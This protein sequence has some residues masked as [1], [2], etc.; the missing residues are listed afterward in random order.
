MVD[1]TP[2][3]RLKAAAIA[4]GC[5]E[6]QAM[7][8]TTE[9]AKAGQSDAAPIAAETVAQMVDPTGQNGCVQAGWWLWH[10]DRLRHVMNGRAEPGTLAWAAT[11]TAA[12][13]W[14]L[15]AAHAHAVH[16]AVDQAEHTAHRATETLHDVLGFLK[17]LDDTDFLSGYKPPE[18]DRTTHPEEP[19]RHGRRGSAVSTHNSPKIIHPRA[20]LTPSRIEGS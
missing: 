16:G 19:R 1:D 8:A 12:A 14:R 13:L 9:A 10:A 5:A 2:A 17:D 7:N 6:T 3:G 11:G 15:L 20:L 18:Q 4:L